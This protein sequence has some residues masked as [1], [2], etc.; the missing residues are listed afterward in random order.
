MS[1]FRDALKFLVSFF[2]MFI[3][4]LVQLSFFTSLKV[5]NGDFY[6]DTLSKSEYFSLMR[7]DI[8]YGFKNLSMITSIPEKVFIDSVSNEA[9]MQLAYKNIS[10]TESYMKYNNKYVDNKIDTGIIYNNLEKYVEVN[11]IKVDTALKNQ[12]LAV[13]IDAGNIINNHTILFNINQVDKYPQFQSFRNIIKSLYSSKL[14]SIF[15]I[16]LMLALLGFLNKDLPRRMFLW[17]GS[18]FIPA[19]ILTL[20]PSILAL[21]YKLPNRFSIDSTYVKVALRDISLGYIKYFIGTG[22]IVLLLGIG[23]MYIYNYLSNKAYKTI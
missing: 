15:A 18:S 9:I 3:I 23:S 17:V 14:I 19:A 12:L 10:S 8:D 13:S 6:K 1:T 2:L 5:L 20:I 22:I 21:Y 7:K 16:F 11:N 4:I